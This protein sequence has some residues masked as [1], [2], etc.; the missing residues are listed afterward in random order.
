MRDVWGA[1]YRRVRK[2]L[3]WIEYEHER[4]LK[5]ISWIFDWAIEYMVRLFIE[6]SRFKE[7]CLGGGIQVGSRN[8][9]Y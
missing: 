4:E 7:K 3:W 2:A 9:W 8:I 1:N 5:G 6:M